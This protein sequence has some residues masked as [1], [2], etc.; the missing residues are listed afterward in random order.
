MK[1][2]HILETYTDL[3][4][5]NSSYAACTRF[6]DAT[7]NIVSHDKFTRLLSKNDFGPKDLWKLSKEHI[8]EA[9]KNESCSLIIDDTIIE[10]PYTKENSINCWH[11]SH[12]KGRCVKGMQLLTALCGFEHAVVPFS[13]E[14]INKTVQ[15]CELET[16]KVKRKSPVSKNELARSL[17]QRAIENNLNF[18][19][20]MADNWFCCKETLDFIH[21]KNKK[22]IFGIKSN[23]NIY[24]SMEDRE[25]NLG[26]KLRKLN[27]N[28]GDTVPVFLNSLDFPVSLI[29]K[30]FTNENGTQGTLYLVTNDLTLKADDIYSTYQK[31]WKIEVYHKSIKNNASIA[32]A[33]AKVIKTQKNHLFC[34]LYAFVKL[35]SIKLKTERNHF[36]L[37]RSIHIMSL[38][39]CRQ[40]VENMKKM[41]A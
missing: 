31:R 24:N 33:P 38:K 28:E 19:Y 21:K 41:I 39:Y 25:K 26:V 40:Q 1:N 10:K 23:R 17:I 32:K 12:A 2:S 13:Y 6:S 20:V 37:K 27:L 4:I 9:S 14:V 36:N 22:F 7:G 29:K 8:K 15:Y 5:A 35:E 34:A 11:Y 18:N 16:R 30:V 3:L